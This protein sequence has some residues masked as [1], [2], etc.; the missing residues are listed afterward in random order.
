MISDLSGIATQF[1]GGFWI[2]YNTSELDTRAYT[3]ST[4]E[5]IIQFKTHHPD[6]VLW[7][8]SSADREC[9]VALEVSTGEGERWWG[10]RG[11]GERWWGERWWGERGWGERGWGER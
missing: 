3:S 5:L 10:E 9:T 6:G 4:E 2:S 11:W 7:A 8:S 1:S